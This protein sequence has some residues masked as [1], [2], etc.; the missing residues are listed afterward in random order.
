MSTSR[1]YLRKRLIAV[2][3]ADLV[4]AVENN[5]GISMYHAAEEAGLIRR[6]PILGSGSPNQTKARLWAMA[7]ITRRAPVPL[8][9]AQPRFSPPPK[10]DVLD[11]QT[12]VK[13]RRTKSAKEPEL[14]KLK[15]DPR[16]LIG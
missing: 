16:A 10:R 3:R 9:P 8:E 12:Q 14:P 13:H 6:R 15:L 4:A 7:K 2:G 5:Q 1:S 11:V